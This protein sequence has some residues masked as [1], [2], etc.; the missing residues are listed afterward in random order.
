MCAAYAEVTPGQLVVWARPCLC[1][2]TCASSRSSSI[3]LPSCAQKTVRACDRPSFPTTA[4][5]RDTSHP[6]VI[7]A[8]PL[9]SSARR[10]CIWSKPV[11]DVLVAGIEQ[12]SS[13]E[14]AQEAVCGT[15]DDARSIWRDV[16]IL[17]DPTFACRD[18]SFRH[19]LCSCA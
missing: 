13:A 1:Q 2:H 5:C 11:P 6:S 12:P 17:M 14:S 18:C 15:G 10:R 19:A 4:S 8:I 9:S 7:S 3:S 16:C